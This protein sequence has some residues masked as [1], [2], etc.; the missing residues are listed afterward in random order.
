VLFASGVSDDMIGAGASGEAFIAK[1]YR[2]EALLRA[3]EIVAGM[4]EGRPATPPFPPGFH[5]LPF[6]D[7]LP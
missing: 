6:G 5:L 7:D 3:L 4:M 2:A 1:P